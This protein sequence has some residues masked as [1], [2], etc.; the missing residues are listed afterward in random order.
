MDNLVLNF[1][2]LLWSTGT[3]IW[4]PYLYR[5]LLR[6]GYSRGTAACVPHFFQKKK[7]PGTGRVRVRYGLGTGEVESS[8]KLRRFP[9]KL[10]DS[11]SLSL[12]SSLYRHSHILSLPA[13]MHSELRFGLVATENQWG[14]PIWTCGFFLSLWLPFVF[15]RHLSLSSLGLKA[16]APFSL[17]LPFQTQAAYFSLSSCF[18]ASNFFNMWSWFSLS[19]S[20]PPTSKKVLDF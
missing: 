3:A 15:T 18:T 10:F 4:A 5:V 19:L 8:Q 1:S 2:V 14:A 9:A 20:Q 12:P 11:Q 6:Y 17:C 7:F 13:T 16:E